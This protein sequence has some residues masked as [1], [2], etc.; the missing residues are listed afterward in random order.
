METKKSEVKAEEVKKSEEAQAA[1][2][3]TTEAPAAE[4]QP[5]Q[6]AAPAAPEKKLAAGLFQGFTLGS[7][8]EQGP[9]GNVMSNVKKPMMDYEQTYK[10]S[11]KNQQL[12]AEELSKLAPKK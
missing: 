4:A 5:A 9:V 10:Q 11:S 7:T 6:E 8:L 12:S 1:E 3:K 2:A